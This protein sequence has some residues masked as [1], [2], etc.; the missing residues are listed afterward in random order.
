MTYAMIV[1]SL[2]VVGMVAFCVHQHIGC[3][4]RLAETDRKHEER[5]TNTKRDHEEEAAKTQRKHEAHVAEIHGFYEKLVAAERT[6]AKAGLRAHVY[7]ASV[8]ER[9]MF[10]MHSKSLVLAVVI[11][12]GVARD[13]VGDLDYLSVFNIPPEIK[14][15]IVAALVGAVKV[16]A[17]GALGLP[18]LPV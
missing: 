16:T 7:R 11:D 18:G 1:L 17:T 8:E 5:A 6:A 2:A 4:K 3:E 10:R 15:A 12:N 13:V 9:G 14:Q